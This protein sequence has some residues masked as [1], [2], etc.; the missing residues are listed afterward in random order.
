MPRIILAAGLGQEWIEILFFGLAFILWLLGKVFGTNQ[1]PPARRPPGPPAARPPQPVPGDPLQSEIEEFL[2]RA[3]AR[4]EGGAAAPRAPNRQQ[5]VK[6]RPPG[7]KPD[8]RRPRPV[9]PT[10][11]QQ[12]PARAEPAVALDTPAGIDQHVKDYLSTSE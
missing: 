5:P 10:T 1:Q 4:K 2:R 12:K 11:A 8:P 9:Q 3:S 6:A 7:A